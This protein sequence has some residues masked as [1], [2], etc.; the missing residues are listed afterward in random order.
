MDNGIAISFE[1]VSKVFR[2]GTRGTETLKETI[3][4]SYRRTRGESFHALD[5][6]S[7]EVKQGEILSIIGDNGSGKST[8]LKIMAG[9]TQP[10]SGHVETRGRIS[11]LL[12]VGAGFHPEMTGRENIFLSGTVLGIDEEQLKKRVDEIIA[13][14]ELEQFI[15]TP[16]KFYSTGMFTRLGFS[17]AMNADP[18]ILLLDEVYSVGDIAF[19][20]RCRDYIER[21]RTTGKTIV[22]VS[23]DL[24]AVQ[25][26][27]SQAMFLDKGKIAKIGHPADTLFEYHR[28]V[29]EQ[30]LQKGHGGTSGTGRFFN[31]DGTQE[32]CI[33]GVRFL[34]QEGEE[35]DH[36]DVC[37]PVTVALDF[38]NFELARPV[39]LAV[40]IWD[41]DLDLVFECNSRDDGLAL[42]SL[43]ERGT[44]H[45]TIPEMLLM[46]AAYF[47]SAAIMD[48]DTDFF[49]PEIRKNVI[50]AHSFRYSFVIRRRERAAKRRGV[51]YLHRRWKVE[52]GGELISEAST[53]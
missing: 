44:I 34:D 45:L 37:E 17:V 42:D 8:I 52:S 32:A 49:A 39:T 48:R 1:N 25:M 43:P 28:H 53:E 2:L 41:R 50:D 21:M 16:M 12:E 40:V 7:F 4:S 33:T 27:S 18:D 47:V 6:V 51:V 3:L 5:N 19:Q 14:A 46:P 23:H 26:V 9:I 10:T 29:H 36:F 38:R 11:A 24:F 30:Q 13:F 15:D 31:R 22:F 35:R 20:Q